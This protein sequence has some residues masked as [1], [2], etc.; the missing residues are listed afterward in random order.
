MLRST[1]HRKLRSAISKRTCHIK[2][3]SDNV[4]KTFLIMFFTWEYSLIQYLPSLSLDIHYCRIVSYISISTIKDITVIYIFS[5]FLY[6]MKHLRY[7]LI[8]IFISL[9]QFCDVCKIINIFYRE[10]HRPPFC[11]YVYWEWVL[12][13]SL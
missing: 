10:F 13:T 4:P 12:A 7:E 2:R 8:P 1:K 11:S 6:G 9:R 5:H 3:I